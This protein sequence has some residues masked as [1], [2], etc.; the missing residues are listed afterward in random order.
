MD[1]PRKDLEHLEDQ[2]RT[3]SGEFGDEAAA[4]HREDP[5]APR[6]QTDSKKKFNE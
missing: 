3:F 2:R 6:E 5:E 1:G 4:E